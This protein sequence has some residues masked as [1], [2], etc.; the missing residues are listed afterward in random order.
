MIK[1]L[2]A[3]L[4]IILAAVPVA[5]LT[6]EQQKIVLRAS[7]RRMKTPADSVKTLYDIYDLSPRAEQRKVAREIYDVSLRGKDYSAC[8]DILRHMAVLDRT[9]SVSD[10]LI[11]ANTRLPDSQER[12]ETDLFLR[13]MRVSHEARYHT[14]EQLHK[15]L[16]KLIDEEERM[17]VSDPRR[18]IMRL[19]TIVEYLSNGLSGKI[20]VKYVDKLEKAMEEADFKLYAVR[21]LVLT[22]TANLY[23]SVGEQERAVAANRE[24]LEVIDGLDEKYRNAGRNYRDYDVS[25][26]VVYRRMLHNSEALQ[27]GEADKYYNA[28]MEIAARNADVAADISN[29]PKVTAHYAM[30]KKDYATAKTALQKVL[31]NEKSIRNR[32]RI[33][34]ELCMAAEAT[35]DNA[36]LS[37]ALKEYNHILRECDSLDSSEQYNELQVRFNLNELKAENTRLELENKEEQ[38]SSTRRI[39]SFVIFGWILC[40]CLLIILLFFWTRYRRMAINLRSFADSL[41]SERDYLKK[42]HYQDNR[43]ALGNSAEKQTDDIFSMRMPDKS[44]ARALEYI[45]DDVV[46]ISSIS[47]D[48]RDKYICNVS[49]NNL[50]RD[51]ERNGSS[52]LAPGQQLIVKI[53]EETIDVHI[54]RECLEYVAQKILHNAVTIG[55]EGNVEIE[56]RLMPGNNE[57]RLI[58]YTDGITIPVGKEETV[59]FGI[60]KIDELEKRRDSGLFICRL[61]AM[62]LDCSVSLDTTCTQGTRCIFTIPLR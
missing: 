20:L 47:K 27:P 39:M 9:D 38:I 48:E 8:M 34:E 49:I 3:L 52:D 12:S 6:R 36:V 41:A 58:Y 17:P 30:I 35:N 24:L 22:E 32:R 59:F 19:Y 13:M 54:D 46:Y 4:L 43:L 7:L 10:L 23:S 21:N 55:R 62:L 31:Q 15:E 26:Y 1:K 45:L 51:L 14:Q 25:R 56:C 53:P 50:M 2:T 61:I 29:N 16:A 44:M 11:S 5:A 57:V 42:I 18:K 28:I 60:I 37:K 33:L 40:A